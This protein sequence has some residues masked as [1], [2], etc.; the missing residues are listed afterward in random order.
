MLFSVISGSSFLL[1]QRNNI[2]ELISISGR[3]S[4][5]RQRSTIPTNS[6]LQHHLAHNPH[7]KNDHSRMLGMGREKDRWSL[8]LFRWCRI[9][10]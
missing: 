3:I 2:D 4:D 9:R 1:P 5:Q 10:I 6:P 8:F 7:R